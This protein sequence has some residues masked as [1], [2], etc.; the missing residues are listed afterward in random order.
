VP[1]ETNEQMGKG[2]I[3]ALLGIMQREPDSYGHLSSV[4]PKVTLPR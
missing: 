1:T 4:F 2:I 3:V